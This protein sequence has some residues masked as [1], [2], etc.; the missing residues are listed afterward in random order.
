MQIAAATT[1][2]C[3]VFLTNDRRIPP[4]PGLRI[5]ALDSYC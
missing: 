3:S 4:I 1:N 2:G 5:V